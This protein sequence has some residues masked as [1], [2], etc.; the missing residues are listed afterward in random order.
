MANIT[1]VD[2]DENIVE[3]L[4][5][6]FEAE[7]Y[8]VRA[9]HDGAA[10][11]AG[12]SENPPDIAI[13]DV[14]MPKMDGMELLRRLRQKSDLPVIFLTSKDGEPDE[15]LGL[16]LGADD[17]IAKGRLQIDELEMRIA[18]AVRSQK[19]EVENVSLRQRLDEKFGMENIVGESPA[20]KEIFEVVQQVAP[21]RATVLLLGESGTGKELVAG[22]IHEHSQRNHRPPPA[23]PPMSGA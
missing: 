21:T 22:A 13:L 4:K 18:R 8:Q 7:G 14:K 12:L 3:S 10:A 17:Y 11:F 1:L 6:F 16:A 20:M 19:L 15:A 2:D 9:Y 23:S 5:V